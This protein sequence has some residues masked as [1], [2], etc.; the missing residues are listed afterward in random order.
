MK[1]ILPML[2]TSTGGIL[3]SL[4]G[5]LNIL[6][7]IPA[8][9]TS[10]VPVPAGFVEM[11]RSRY[12]YIVVPIMLVCGWLVGRWRSG[13]I[14]GLRGW[15]YWVAMILLGAIVGVFGY[16]ASLVLFFLSA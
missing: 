6:V 8:L 13:Q 2:F 9:V 1:K 10:D 5:Y 14:E 15:R 4:Y 7:T 12:F 11:Y 16:F 3:G